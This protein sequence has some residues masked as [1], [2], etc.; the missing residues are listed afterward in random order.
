MPDNITEEIRKAAILNAVRHGGK[1]NPKVVLGALLGEHQE[2]RDQIK[3]IMP[4]VHE[5]VQN[6][7][8]MS[9]QTLRELAIEKWPNELS[10]ERQ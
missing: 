8:S 6:I 2:L 7:N 9:P 4:L 1:A 3:N 10:R 5:I